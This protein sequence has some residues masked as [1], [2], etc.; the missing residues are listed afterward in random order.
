LLIFPL[1]ILKSAENEPKNIKLQ[2]NYACFL[3]II[4]SLYPFWDVLKRFL[5]LNMLVY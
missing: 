4:V 3:E 1:K 2:Q 5:L